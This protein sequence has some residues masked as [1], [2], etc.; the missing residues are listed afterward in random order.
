[1]CFSWIMKAQQYPLFSHYQQNSFGFNPAVAGCTD[2]P[3]ARLVYRQQWAGL[4]ESPT[5]QILSMHGKFL[6]KLPIGLGGYVFND[7][8]GKLKRSGGSAAATF[9]TKLDSLTNISVGLGFGYYNI[10]IDN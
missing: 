6:K 9:I 8:A 5:T 1:M 7:E 2:C 4:E 10:R 3:E